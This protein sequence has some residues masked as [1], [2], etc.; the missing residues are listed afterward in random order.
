M[1][2]VPLPRLLDAS[3]R[4]V[5]RLHPLAASLSLVTPGTSEATLTLAARDPRP[6]MH[7]WVELYTQHGSAGMYRVTGISNTYTGE[8]QIT[9]RHG[10]DTLSDSVYMAQA[11]ET[12][13]TVQQLL[14][15]ILSYQTARVAGHAPWQL[16]TVADN[17]TLK[18]AF[19][20]DNL[21]ELL[22]GIAEE[23]QGYYFTYDFSTTPWTL[24]FVQKPAA[25]ASE[26]RLSR[27]IESL[28]VSLDDSELCTQLLLSVNVMT[29]T[30]PTTPDDPDVDWPT[31][32]AN[33][34]VVRTYNN[35]AAQAQ[36][37]I[38]QKTASID[39]QDDIAG[40]G[41]PNADAWAA[42]FM[43][44][45]SQ[46]T[47]QIQISGEDL[48]EITG[49]RY[50]EHRLAYL[51]RV[52]LPDHDA[53]FDERVVAIGYPDIY[54]A[55]TRVTVSL[56][57]RLPKFSN[58]IAQAQQAA[59]KADSTAKTAK[60]SAGGGGGGTAK[61]LESWAMI[62]KKS[63]EAEDAT[64]ITEMH[65]TGILLDAQTGA[66]LYSLSQGFVSQYAELNV[67][68]GQISS[69]VQTTNGLDSRITQTATQIQTEVTN[70]EN[71]DQT[72]SSRITQTADA[73]TAEVTRATTAEGQMSS[74][75][76][77]TADAITAEVTRAT[78]AE[79]NLSSRITIN[80]NGIETKVSKNGVISAINQTAESVTISASKINL[81]GYVT[82]S[83]L[84]STNAAINNLVTGV[85]SASKLVASN[86]NFSNLEITNSL[87]YGG[88]GD[89]KS[90][91]ISGLSSSAS[92]GQITISS[93]CLDNTAGPSVNFNIADTQYYKN[94]VSAAWTNAYNTV[95]INNNKDPGAGNKT[96]NLG[97][98]QSVEVYA[99]AKDNANA[100]IWTTVGTVTV[101]A[102]TYT[103]GSLSIASNGIYNAPTY[104]YTGFS[105][106][107]V[108][109]PSSPTI[110]QCYT[111]NFSVSSISKYGDG[112]E[113]VGSVYVR[114]EFSDNTHTDY[115]P[116]TVRD[117]T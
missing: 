46:P 5:G 102:P 7:Q 61:E 115:G 68:S 111:R 87:V 26:F 89:L 86:G 95:R 69:L 28:A 109:V 50:D 112:Y 37:G 82:T 42:R 33:D 3:L 79:G 51:C 63:K 104:G 16:G 49:D 100:S 15:G 2:T 19:N 12:A 85:T 9:L 93:T 99:Q 72:L 71:A 44:D 43:A 110:T 56:A 40:Q 36:W 10:I 35:A 57:N 90:K 25:V 29:T 65:E 24:N 113:V 84:D 107:S 98:G 31:V 88:Y 67:Q 27:N 14:T 101:N 96:I 70:R 6:A 66:K 1:I 21:A 32:T 30:T 54:G 78:D 94:G 62:V 8:C 4:E 73:I 45:H 39:T 17:T 38:V 117:V 64:G 103:L 60:R 20:Y 105:Y 77:Q 114:V 83:Q 58:S 97:S 13:M 108:D 47:L 11:D 59:A 92:G 55:P 75:I 74:R 41:F 22:N 106:V 80:A 34:S 18:R 76:T 81:S 48:K 116:Y 53:V 91:I 23:K 52:A